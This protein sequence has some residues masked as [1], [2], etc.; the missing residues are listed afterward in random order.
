MLVIIPR[1]NEEAPCGALVNR[2]RKESS[3]RLNVRGLQAFVALHDLELNT[4]T[5]G[6]RLVAVHRDRGEVNEHVVPPSRSMNP[7]PFSFENHLTV[8]SANSVLLAG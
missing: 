7:K 3:G 4:L 8:P 1:E 5:L 6:Q 2:F